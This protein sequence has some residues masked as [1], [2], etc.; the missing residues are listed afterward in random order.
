MITTFALIAVICFMIAG[1][2]HLCNEHTENTFSTEHRN[3]LKDMIPYYEEVIRTLDPGD[4][5]VQ[6]EK[7]K[8]DKG[9]CWCAFKVFGKNIYEAHWV[10]K[11][12]E[13]STG[14]W[15]TAPL[16]SHGENVKDL[17]QLRVDKMRQI[18]QIY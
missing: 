14:Y 3:L 9:I 5:L 4:E 12:V 6:L 16:F 10:K 11:R 17:L 18:L 1:F 7:L 13:R 15:F 8:V 2:F